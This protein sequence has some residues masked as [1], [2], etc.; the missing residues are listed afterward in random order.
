LEHYIR[1]ERPSLVMIDSLT[2]CL[3]GMNI[4]LARSSAGDAIYGLRDMANAYNCSIVILHHLN[5]SGGLRDSTS[6]VD[7]VSEVVKLTRA[8]SFDP[9]EF[10]IEW[11]KSRSGLTGK[12]S[13]QRDPLNYGWRYAGP[14]GGSLE[15]LDKAASTVNMR[16]DERLTKQQVSSLSDSWDIAATGKMLEVAR[17]QGLITSSFQDGPNGEK[18]RLYHSWEY[19]EPD[20]TFPTVE[21][22]EFF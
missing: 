9:N 3:S 16:K 18:T 5:K 12:H 14:L 17:R 13:L 6:F 8:E 22:E 15:E 4:D 1:K 2:A 21:E 7:N 10:T 11:L 19:Q 20:L